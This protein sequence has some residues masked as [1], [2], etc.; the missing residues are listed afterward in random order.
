M[1]FPVL[2]SRF[3]L[4]IYFIHIGVYMSTIVVILFYRQSQHSTDNGK[5]V[6]NKNHACLLKVQLNICIN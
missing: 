6:I 3:L 4:V 1:E 2:Y 5:L